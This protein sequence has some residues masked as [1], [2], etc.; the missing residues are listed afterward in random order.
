MY[1]RGGRSGERSGAA[2]VVPGDPGAEGEREGESGSEDG[3][4]EVVGAA[5]GDVDGAD[6]GE[7]REGAADGDGDERGGF[8]V[9]AFGLAGWGGHGTADVSRPR[10]ACDGRARGR[11]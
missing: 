4:H 6:E 3:G 7:Q 1:D 11:L 9:L 10:V 8:H 2:A 5:G